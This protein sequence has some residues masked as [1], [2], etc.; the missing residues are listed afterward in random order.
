MNEIVKKKPFYLWG[1][2]CQQL[3]RV[4]QIEETSNNMDDHNKPF[5]SQSKDSFKI[6][7]ICKLIRQTLITKANF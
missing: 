7:T 2:R 5:Q 1:P 3:C 4:G 6:D